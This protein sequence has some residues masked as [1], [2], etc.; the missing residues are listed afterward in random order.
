MIIEDNYI[1]LL[2]LE[3]VFSFCSW[4]PTYR[5]ISIKAENSQTHKTSNLVTATTWTH[6]CVEVANICVSWPAI[7]VS[8]H[9]KKI[10]NWL[11]RLAHCCDWSAPGGF[12]AQWLHGAVVER[13]HAYSK[14][15]WFKSRWSWKLLFT[16][17]LTYIQRCDVRMF[18]WIK[19]YFNFHHNLRVYYVK[20]EP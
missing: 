4:C 7:I 18:Q 9:E 12:M 15:R 11:P 1:V 20:A 5:L 13:S 17:L 3:Y 14:V 6:I 2:D 19:I 16:W 10:S 8:T